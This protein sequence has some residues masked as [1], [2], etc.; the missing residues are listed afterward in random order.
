[1]LDLAIDSRIPAGAETVR[2]F[3][4]RFTLSQINGS[5]EYR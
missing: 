5:M 1:M 4:F 3:P 2:S